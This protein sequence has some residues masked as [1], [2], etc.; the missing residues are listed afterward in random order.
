MNPFFV[1]LLIIIGVILAIFFIHYIFTLPERR[2]NKE[3]LR[4]ENLLYEER[5]QAE[6][7]KQIARIAGKNTRDN[8][9]KIAK[10]K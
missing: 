5:Y 1:V 8:I 9:D 7:A 2:E 10:L 3:R 6:R 4:R